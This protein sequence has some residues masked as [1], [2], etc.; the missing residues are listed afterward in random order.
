MKSILRKLS[1][2]TLVAP[3]LFA[4]GE[5]GM[6][7]H[8]DTTQDLL[9]QCVTASPVITE[10]REEL[11]GPV[12]PGVSKTYFVVVRNASSAACAPATLSFIP[13]AFQFFGAS[14]QPSSI[15]GVAPGATATFRVQVTSDPS[16]QEGVYDIGFTVVGQ[17]GGTSVRGSL[18]YEVDLDNPTGCNRQPPQISV[19]PSSPAAVPAGTVQNYTVTLRNIDNPQCGSEVFS[20]IPDSFRLFSLSTSGPVT[21]PAGGSATVT[22][23]ASSASQVTAG[24]Y[25]LG[26]TVV[27]N[28]HGSLTSRGSVS[29]RVQ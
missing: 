28:R 16:V 1:I 3:V 20:V 27:G 6:D 9:E 22:L 29:Y 8:Y 25:A 26:F 2:A 10:I 23:S 24:T 15:Q 5:A 18:P 12:A 7:E 11:A 14:A 17:P 4:C 19:T 21:I 13:D